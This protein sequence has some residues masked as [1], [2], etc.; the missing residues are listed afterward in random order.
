MS[1]PVAFLDACVLYPQSVRDVFIQFAFDN[2]YQANWSLKVEQ[3]FV[4][5]VEKNIPSTKGK[6]VNTINNMRKTKPDF[7]S[8]SSSQTLALISSTKTDKK[9]IEI[10]SASIDS[11]CTHLITYNLRDFDISF[12]AAK[13]VSI[14]HP[15]E[16]LFQIISKNELAALN[17]FNSAVSRTK[18]PPRTFDDYCNGLRINNLNKTTDLLLAICDK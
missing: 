11:N 7:L 10:L 17:S 3:E 8:E 5:N 16:F 6:L 9:D 2:F 14:I 4:K 12:A 13:A 15:D 18:K 1:K